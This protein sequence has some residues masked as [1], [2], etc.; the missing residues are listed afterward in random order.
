[1][2]TITLQKLNP[3]PLGVYGP[4][5]SPLPGRMAFLHPDAAASLAAL[6]AESGGLVYSDIYRDAMGSLTAHRAKAGVEPPGYSAHG[7]GLAFDL[8]VDESVER[9]G[10][11]YEQLLA[12][13]QSHGW[14][15]YCRDG[16][17]GKEDWHFNWLGDRAANIMVQL[18]LD[19][20]R[21]WWFAA[22]LNILALYPEVGH[23][24]NP[25]EIQKALAE[26]GLYRGAID[27]NLGPLST[28]AAVHFGAAWD[29]PPRGTVFERTL[30]F[31]AA[32]VV[33]VNAAPPVA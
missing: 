27:G 10:K 28:S 1:M 23:R 31:A 33:I 7:Y 26:L 12:L 32:K 8:A 2:L 17:R 20:R 11:S 4:P 3:P 5:G 13:L 18:E 6:E 25:I 21:T 16:Q 24:M 19:N 9:S 30:R 22:E 15:C 14:Y 29:T